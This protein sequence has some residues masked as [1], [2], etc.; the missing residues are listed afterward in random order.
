MLRGRRK[1]LHLIL[2]GLL[3]HKM[4]AVTQYIASLKGELTLHVLPD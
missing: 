2:D 4:K 1:P 3:A